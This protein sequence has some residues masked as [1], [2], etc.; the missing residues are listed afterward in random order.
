MFNVQIFTD[1]AEARILAMQLLIRDF[2]HEAIPQELEAWQRDDMRRRFPKVETPNYVSATTTV[3]PRSR[4]YEQ[5]HRERPLLQRLR[6]R[7]LTA[8]PRLVGAGGGKPG[9]SQRPILRPELFAKLHVR[10]ADIMKRKLAWQLTF[11]P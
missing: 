1:R 11:R 6:R 5:R 3:W 10:M 2:G 8:R 7:A 4:T 9:G